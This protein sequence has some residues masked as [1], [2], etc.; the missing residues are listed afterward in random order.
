MNC[1]RLPREVAYDRFLARLQ[2]AA[3]GEWLLKGGVALDL[4]F[5]RGE[6]RRT[7]D[8]DLETRLP[9]TLQD[10]TLLLNKAMSTALDDFFVFGLTSVPTVVENES[11]EWNL[12]RFVAESLEQCVEQAMDFAKNAGNSNRVVVSYDGFVTAD[13]AKTA[14]VMVLGRERGIADTIVFAQRYTPK[15]FLK[16]FQT[17]GNA[18]FLGPGPSLS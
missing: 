16:K 1:G 12:Q 2:A 5:A 10:A 15:T 13:G 11:R 7:K 6:A 18:T 9:A 4:R 3:P 8:V 14:A 17:V